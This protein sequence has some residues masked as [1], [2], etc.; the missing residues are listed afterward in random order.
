[1]SRIITHD[2]LTYLTLLSVESNTYLLV[3]GLKHPRHFPILTTRNKTKTKRARFAQAT[4]ICF[5][6]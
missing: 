1:M 5:E 6:R 3:I 2:L 4:C